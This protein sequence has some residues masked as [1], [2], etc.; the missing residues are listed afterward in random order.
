MIRHDLMMNN[1]PCK[2]I[3][4][5]IKNKIIQMS[6]SNL[7]NNNENVPDN[8]YLFTQSNLVDLKKFNL[9]NHFVRQSVTDLK[10]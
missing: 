4:R 6:N 9:N 3:D 8:D 10:F 7:I 1:Y 5:H 2:F